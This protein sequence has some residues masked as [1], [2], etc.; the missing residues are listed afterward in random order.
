MVSNFHFLTTSRMYCARRASAVHSRGSSPG[1][2]R[3]RIAWRR[4]VARTSAGKEP[5]LS[6]L[7]D[8]LNTILELLRVT[9]DG[10]GIPGELRDRVF[11]PFVSGRAGGSGLGLA[12]V[13]RAV[14]AHRGVVLVDT[15]RAGGTVFSVVIPTKGTSEVAA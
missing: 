6:G 11:E 10:P 13:Q 15:P 9:D 2:P 3:L 5:D 7:L 8:L 4:P 14:Q 12:I 1:F